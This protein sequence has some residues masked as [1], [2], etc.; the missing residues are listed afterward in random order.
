MSSFVEFVL[1]FCH[2][3]IS[4]FQAPC[5]LWPSL[6]SFVI[7]HHTMTRWRRRNC[8]SK[9]L[10]RVSKQELWLNS[11]V[12]M[13]TSINDSNSK[14]FKPLLPIIHRATNPFWHSRSHT[15]SRNSNSH[16]IYFIFLPC[17]YYIIIHFQEST[18]YRNRKIRHLSS[19]IWILQA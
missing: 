11:S 14:Y 7:T 12:L 1:L 5:H 19:K 2:Y 17:F 18:M 3:F 13:L 6:S 15:K 9:R 16:H 8:Q 4:S 10:A